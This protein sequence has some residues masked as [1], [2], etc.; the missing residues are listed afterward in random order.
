MRPYDYYSVS[1]RSA[2]NFRKN[3]VSTKKEDDK[4]TSAKFQK[5]FQF[6]LYNMLKIQS[7]KET[8]IVDP[9]ETAH[10]EPSH[11]NLQYLQIH[12]AFVVF[13]SSIKL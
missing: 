7:L 2:Q 1:Y 9:D 5:H 4:M 6:K 8:N 3:S 11:L 13:C 10:N 12:A